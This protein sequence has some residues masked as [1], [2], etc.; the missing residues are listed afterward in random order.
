VARGTRR[1]VAYILLDAA[2]LFEA[3]A[4]KLLLQARLREW[5]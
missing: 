3:W 5:R 4:H 1:T 2:S